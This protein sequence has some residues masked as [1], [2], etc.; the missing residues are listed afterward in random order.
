MSATESEIQTAIRLALARVPGVVLWRNSTGVAIHDPGTSRA[1]TRRYGLSP[2]S[3]DLVGI[4]APSGRFLA[5]EVKRPGQ[6]PRPEQVRFLEL[7]RRFSGFAAVVDS[8]DSALA[9]VE[10]ARQGAVE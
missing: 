4:L 8:V 3:A 9:A 6:S 10:R 2:G 1:R 7:V 5:L